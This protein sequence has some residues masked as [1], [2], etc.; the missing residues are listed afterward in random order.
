MDAQ[1]PPA[2]LANDGREHRRRRLRTILWTVGIIL[3][4]PVI[5]YLVLYITK[6]RFL[7]G[8]FERYASERAERPVRVA[9]D[10]QLYLNPHVKFLAEG[11]T[12]ANPDWARDD[13]LFRARLIDTEVDIWKLIVSFGDNQ[14]LRFL[15]LDGA[16]GGL[17]RDARG[18]NTWTFA[19]DEPLEL[20][21]IVRAAIKDSRLRY[22][23]AKLRAD[24]D[25][26]FGDVAGDR[27]TDAGTGA[28]AGPLT[29][30]GGGRI[31]GAP[32]TIRGALTN[33]NEAAGG[34][35][36][37]IDLTAN[38]ASTRFDVAG[39]LPGATVLDG[40]DLRITMQGRN[41]Q[42]PFLLAGVAMPATRPYKLS[43]SFTKTGNEYRLTR[44]NGRLGDSDIAGD[45]TLR[46]AEPR[47][48]LTGNLRTRKLD[49]LDVGPLFGW[50]P[51]KLDAQGGKGAIEQVNGTPRILPDAPL[52][53]DALDAFDA[54][55]DYRAASIRTGSVPLSNLLLT[56]GLD[57]RRLTLKP[58]ELDLA[59]GRLTADIDLDARVRPVVT[60]YDI[61]LS[62]VPLGKVLT[63]FDVEKA[64]TSA[65][66]RGR[67]Q[68][69]GY[70]DTLRQSLATSSGRI[71]IVLPRGTLWIRNA[72]LGEL[73]L[74][75]FL[76]ALLGKKLEKPHAI[77]CG[78][79]AFTVKDGIGRVDPI[80]VDTDRTVFRG[81]G[82]IS[83]KDESLR[84]SIEGDSKKFSLFSG[85]SPIA[86]NG[87]FAAPSVN[88]ISG[89]LLTRAGAGL[90]LGLVATP[91]AA[92]AAFVDFGDEKDTDCTPVLAARTTPAVRVADKAAEKR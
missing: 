59:G 4:L 40:A 41:F 73:D 33:P 24:V 80:F 81:Q 88:P 49:V 10:F 32:F 84:L 44:V 3:S 45:L 50:S 65:S 85:Q 31:A 36:V 7:K 54:A 2:D 5:A 43:A 63:S 51:Q 46:N 47:P 20:P 55:I 23:D 37:K 92:I 22:R 42:E 6:G 83:F 34:G 57:D 52:A 74:Q 1:T 29:F 62:A 72:E 25:I 82:T 69:K 67:V 28:I 89:E 27:R 71:A 39:T 90:A 15:T 60:D 86:I 87:Y 61:R 48:R 56:F 76:V 14:Q 78:L 58:V 91:I 64:G 8:P 17:E 21:T 19:G 30:R 13:N 26:R 11:M 38:A 66:V 79:V 12:V 68:L 75:G 9:G 77:R 70:G 35:R 16:T 18:R 53:A